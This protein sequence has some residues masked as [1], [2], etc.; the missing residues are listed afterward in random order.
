MLKL[1][2]SVSL[3]IIVKNFNVFSDPG[4]TTVQFP[5]YS[6]A[7]LQSEYTK[8]DPNPIQNGANWIW[9]NGTSRFATFETLFYSYA[10]TSGDLTIKANNTFNVFLNGISMRLGYKYAT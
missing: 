2:I 4:T 7:I 6:Y 5:L 8:A 9:T 10:T 3:L 1:F